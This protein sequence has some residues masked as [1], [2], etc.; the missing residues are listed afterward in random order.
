V[1]AVTARASNGNSGTAALLLEDEEDCVDVVTSVGVDELVRV[2]LEE[3]E[4]EVELEL[5][6]IEVGP[7]LSTI[8]VPFM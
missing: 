3:V 4:F 5:V 1:T 6:E 7:A 8:T 2:L